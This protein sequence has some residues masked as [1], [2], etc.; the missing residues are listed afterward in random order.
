MIIS[1]S[2]RTDI[3]SFYADWFF[4]RIKAGY[5]FV[6]NPMNPHQISK[7][8]LSKDVVDCIVFWTKNPIPMIDRL[9]EIKDYHYYFHFTLNAYG[10]DIE[11]NVPNK[12][13]FIIPSF[14]KLSNKIGKEKVIWRYDPIFFNDKYT[15]DYHIKYFEILAKKLSNYTEKC[16]ISFVDYYKN[17]KNNAKKLNITDISYNE[18]I[19]LLKEFSKIAKKY[20][21]ILE[22]CAEDV[23]LLNL[24]INP[25]KC[26][27]KDLLEKITGY[28]LDVKKDK[29]QR[30]SC[31]CVLSIDIGVYNT[32][33][34][35]CLYCYANFNK[36]LVENNLLKYNKNSPLL[37][38]NII[39]ENS[40]K[41]RKVF[42]N[43]INQLNLYK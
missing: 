29:N 4:N 12:N 38:K 42:S 25:S 40:I 36:T 1:A 30:L 20:N 2:R 6:Q 35:S 21:L 41:D 11:E 28:N 13:D 10:K 33:N 26:I 7:I 23:E 17:T 34:N 24:D 8:D 22:T 37:C 14:I 16:V 15:F 31:G 27:D 32:C 5:V 18:K 19:N 39:D 9:D 3:P 43:K